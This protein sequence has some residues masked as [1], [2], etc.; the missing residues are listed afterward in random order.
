MFQCNFFFDVIH[1]QIELELEA[2]S[3]KVAGFQ[4]F[5]KIPFFN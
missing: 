2:F 3:K 4:N 1:L 5:V